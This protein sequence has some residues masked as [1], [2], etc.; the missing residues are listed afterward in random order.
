MK[1]NVVYLYRAVPQN[2][3]SIVAETFAEVVG[4]LSQTHAKLVEKE[5]FLLLNK[6]RKETAMTRSTFANII[7][8]LW[9]MKFYRI[10]V[11][12]TQFFNS[13]NLENNFRLV[14]LV[15]LKMALDFWIKL[16][17]IISKLI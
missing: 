16:H 11:K 12:N 10:K 4:V 17:H 8:L 7:S 3:Y 9:A 1:L 2:N 15:K 14:K 6:Y 13:I 5:F